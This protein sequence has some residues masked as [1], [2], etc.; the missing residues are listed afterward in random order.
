MRH[1]IL[2][3]MCLIF[4]A[5]LVRSQFPPEGYFNFY[6]NRTVECIDKGVI[7]YDRNYTHQDLEKLRDARSNNLND[8]FREVFNFIK[9]RDAASLLAATGPFGPLLITMMAISFVTL[10]AFIIWIFGVCRKVHNRCLEEFTVVSSCIIYWAYFGVWVTLVVFTGL[11]IHYSLRGFCAYL[12][13]GEFFTYGT[14][15]ITNATNTH[16][17]LLNAA[18]SIGNFTLETLPYT[19]TA[20]RD[21]AYKGIINANLPGS[22]S[23][24]RTSLENF[25]G[26]YSQ[27]KIVS[28]DGGLHVSRTVNGFID[29]YLDPRIEADSKLLTSASLKLHGAAETLLSYGTVNTPATKSLSTLK[30]QMVMVTREYYM[31]MGG[32]AYAWE[33]FMDRMIRNK[34]YGYIGVW[35]TFALNLTNVLL[36]SIVMSILFCVCCY[37]KCMNCVWLAKILLL[38]IA[39][40]T[41]GVFIVNLFILFGS[42]IVSGHCHY[43]AQINSKFPNS[44]IIQDI[45]ITMN[46]PTRVMWRK[47]VDVNENPSIL[48]VTPTTPSN[49]LYYGDALK[50]IDGLTAYPTFEKYFPGDQSAGFGETVGNWTRTLNGE[51]IDFN[52]VDG[53][54]SILNQAI[55]CGGSIYAIKKAGCPNWPDFKCLS[56]YDEGTVVTPSCMATSNITVAQN[57]FSNLKLYSNSVTDVYSV[58][59]SDISAANPSYGGAQ[60]GPWAEFNRAA[61]LVRAQAPHFAVMQNAFPNTTAVANQYNYIF[62][63]LTNCSAIRKELL[64]TEDVACFKGDFYLYTYLILSIVCGMLLFILEWCICGALREQDNIVYAAPCPS[65]PLRVV[66]P[67]LVS[68]PVLV[69]QAFAQPKPTTNLY[70]FDDFEVVPVY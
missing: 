14:Q 34:N 44:T 42:V 66:Q 4:L 2:S 13:V 12:T 70:D 57:I 31:F 32:V 22:A 8:Y 58:M 54:L 30:A 49:N 25:Y 16:M 65:G 23:R 17:G 55:M 20:A 33:F 69:G 27:A 18:V 1:T 56:I 52:D 40:F 60:A 7:I 24:L 62:S 10:L 59:I 67:V 50:I 47:C 38:F 35:F 61:A 26:E 46:E 64:K 29:T 15:R 51:T 45:G 3:L 19:G 53:N 28:A 36:L 41:I 43:L 5:G 39:L 21:A 68:Q 6:G 48:E 11:A 37:R 63:E 9:T